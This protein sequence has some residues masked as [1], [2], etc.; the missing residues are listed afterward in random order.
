M[1]IFLSSIQE[2]EG[3]EFEINFISKPS[4]KKKSNFWKFTSSRNNNEILK[5]VL[6]NDWFLF[7]YNGKYMYA[8]QVKERRKLVV[9]FKNL[10]EIN[11]GFVKTNNELGISSSMPS[12]HR[13]P[14][15]D[16][17]DSKT[18]QII[19]KYH[20]IEGFLHERKIQI[21]KPPKKIIKEINIEPASVKKI[22]KKI[23]TT[24]VRVIRDTA[25]TKKLKTRYDN[26]CQVC[27]SKIAENYSDVH[28]VWPIGDDGD[29]DYDNMLVL[30]PNHHA[31][32][33]LALIEFDESRD[34]QIRWVNS[35]EIGKLYFQTDHRIHRK[36]VE[37][38]NMRVK[39]VHG[40]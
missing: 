9:S 26:I 14:L 22:P 23:K 32:F 35:K 20:S 31:M 28:H 15:L 5:N 30:C 36:N 13:I 2:K 27:R 10:T 37:H 24:I 12:V 17:N 34:G 21:K 8:A 16:V 19:K 1:K 40:T 7:A 25:R 29:D 11:R 4:N 39:K 38:N 6:K 33:D 18:Q 3:K